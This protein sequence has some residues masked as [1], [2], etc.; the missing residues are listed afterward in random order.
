M[1]STSN[2]VCSFWT[3]C[4]HSSSFL[5]FSPIASIVPQTHF[6]IKW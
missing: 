1:E 2:L 5:I 6:Q 4:I 3:F